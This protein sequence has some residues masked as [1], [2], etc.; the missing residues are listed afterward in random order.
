MS[1]KIENNKNTEQKEPE[2]VS[3]NKMPL[4]AKFILYP[5]YFFVGLIISILVLINLPATQNFIANKAIDLINKDFNAGLKF[6][7]VE[8]NF[9]GD[10]KI[11]KVSAKDHRGFEFIKIK[12]IDAETDW[13]SLVFN[14]SNL[15]FNKINVVEP[16]IRVFTYKG[17][18]K[19]NFSRYLANFSSEKK[20]KKKKVFKMNTNL[21]IINGKLS[22]INQNK[23]GDYGAWLNAWDVNLSVINFNVLGP[24][25]TA[26]INRFTFKT[27]RWG[28][29]HY[30][31]TLSTDF[32]LSP[33]KLSLQALTFNTDHTLLQGDFTLKLD[34]KT[35]WQDFGNKVKWDMVLKQGSQVSGYDI[36]YFAPNWDNYVPIKVSG[37]V[38]GVLNDFT[39]RELAFKSDNLSIYT[40]EIKAKNITNKNFDIKT[41]ELSFLFTYK[42]LKAALPSFIS[43]KMGNFA[44]DFGT[45]KYSGT[46]S[47]NANSIYSKGNVIS[48]IGQVNM[49]IA[50]RDFSTKTP[51]YKG[52]LLVYQLNIEALAKVKQVGLVSGR[53]ILEGEGFNLNTLRLRTKSDIRSIDL[54]G[55][56]LNNIIIDGTLAQKKFNGN[57]SINSEQVKGKINGAL[58][59]SSPR[60]ST[61]LSAEIGYVNLNYFG[62]KGENKTFRGNFVGKASFTNVNDITV[63]AQ[64]NDI[65]FASGKQNINIQE[66]KLQAF[67][68]NSDRVVHVNIPNSVEGTIKGKYQLKELVNM[69]EEGISGILVGDKPARTFK[70]Q[71]FNFNFSV[72]QNLVNFLDPNLKIYENIEIDG[73]Y[74]GDYNHLILNANLLGLEYLAPKKEEASVVTDL[75]NQVPELYS[76]PPVEEKDPIVANHISLGIDTSD[77]SNQFTTRV[78]RLQIN[79]NIFQNITLLGSKTDD[80]QFRL[81]VQFMLGTPQDEKNKTMKPQSINLSQS[82]DGEGNYVVKFDPTE[83]RLKNVS[84]KIDT[85]KELNHS[86]VYNKKSKEIIVNSLRFYSDNDEF[87]VNGTFKNAKNF[88]AEIDLKNLDISKLLELANIGNLNMKGIADGKLDLVI[89]E[90]N[91]KPIVNL[92]IKDFSLNDHNFGDLVIDAGNSEQRN[93]FDLNAQIISKNLTSSEKLTLSG[94]IDNNTPSPTL[95]IK[96]DVKDFDLGFIEGFAKTVFSNMRGKATG[97]LTL[98]GTLKDFNYNGDLRI[99][100]FGLKLIFSGVDYTFQDSNVSIVNG[101][102]ILDQIKVADGRKNSSGTISGVLMLGNFTSI[103]V[104]LIARADNLMLLDTTQSNFDVFWGK[105]F[106][107][108][109]G[110][111]ISYDKNG[112]KI[113]TKAEVLNNSIFTL[114]SN[115]SSSVEE[116]KVLRFLKRD[117]E[118]GEIKVD[119]TR[120]A[121]MNIEVNLDLDVD[122]G[123]VV[124]VLVGDEIGDITARGFAKGLKFSMNKGIMSMEGAF[125]V[126][127]GS[128]V[129]KAILEK[130]FHISKGSRI[131]WD[132]DV[133]NPSLDISAKYS[134]V[135]TNLGEYLSVGKIPPVDIDLEAKI[136]KNLQNPNLDFDIIAPDVS[137][138][139]RETLAQKMINQDEKVIQFG[140][141][142]VLNNFIVSNNGDGNGINVSSSLGSTGVNM[143]VKQLGSVFNLISQVFQIDINYIAAN[144]QN[145]TSDRAVGNIDFNFSPRVTLKTGLGVP[146]TK[147]NNSQANNFTGEGTVE[148]DWSKNNDGSRIFRVYSK[149]SNIGLVSGENAGANQT[150]GFGV[151]YSKNFNTI[152]RK[153]KNKKVSKR[154]LKLDSLVKSFNSKENIKSK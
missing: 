6:E 45:L 133:M 108:S 117:E 32:E 33:Q 90:A 48:G 107:K 102:L 56:P 22:I 136:T 128:Y 15:V 52:T 122:K 54:L 74:L 40:P 72:A 66:G 34:S 11:N 114:N 113:D 7:S 85:S 60:I 71:S 77:P 144:S 53:V 82:I 49:D 50:L 37:D 129:S 65:Q 9:F 92:K 101:N 13:F 111:F 152:F 93:V 126:D 83:I 17:E 123:S 139:I 94:T 5:F 109:E 86:I 57:I 3:K 59:F 21:K 44:D 125:T 51:K 16:D 46:T 47:V 141:I 97:Q 26:H 78:R 36:S 118:S 19:D 58:D 18:D 138:Q 149:P 63:D 146:I 112:L 87:F 39:I 75:I 61:E 79:K 25:L 127:S 119:D 88:D 35:G 148:Y 120:K 106:A 142:L 110:I 10:V 30:L 89:D 154:K 134:R 55:K 105:V 96:M 116:F 147:S 145:N 95:D 27:K 98:D 103:G 62:L 41:N 42:S 28:K 76:M 68:E 4:W 143:L 81:A 130:I 153:N 131:E 100:D 150:Y 151:V 70:G 12:Q 84:W 135:V 99:K 43:K 124:N 64:V 73:S 91:L 132:N 14:S 24:K 115:S 104:N 31:E 69:F 29:E 1:A 80:N 20:K 67:F 137:A 2:K 140:S 38:K 121:A 23:P 8:I